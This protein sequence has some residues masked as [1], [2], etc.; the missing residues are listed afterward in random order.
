[1]RQEQSLMEGTDASPGV[2]F[3]LGSYGLAGRLA[4]VLV[5]CF[6]GTVSGGFGAFVAGLAPAF[7]L[8][9]LRGEPE[10]SILGLTV[11]GA[12]I[13]AVFGTVPGF[14]VGAYIGISPTEKRA[15]VFLLLALLAGCASQWAVGR[16]IDVG[17]W[18]FCYCAPWLSL[19]FSVPLVRTTKIRLGLYSRERAS[20]VQRQVDDLL[21]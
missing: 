18:C 12:W 3:D 5:C 14:I 21:P 20:E 8:A 9:A 15:S 11:S 1:M 2:L 10:P 16:P 17:G 13:W 4:G 6:V 7:A 19:L